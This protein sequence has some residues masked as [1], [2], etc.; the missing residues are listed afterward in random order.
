MNSDSILKKLLDNSFEFIFTLY[1]LSGI[2]KSVILSNFGSSSWFDITIFS[3]GI[4]TVFIIGNILTNGISFYFNG[5][6]WRVISLL[7][8]YLIAII[9]ISY[10]PS[11]NYS[12]YKAFLFLTNVLA[13]ISP[14]FHPNF[15]IYRFI[16][17]IGVF[18][19]LIGVYSFIVYGFYFGVSTNVLGL[20]K[21]FYRSFYLDAGYI[22]GLA[23]ILTLKLK[24]SKY[25]LILLNLSA[26]LL[27]SSAARGPIIFTFISFLIYVSGI[28]LDSGIKGFFQRI[29]KRKETIFIILAVNTLI[30]ITIYSTSFGSTVFNRTLYRFSVISPPNIENAILLGQQSAD[31]DDPF[32]FH[33]D[34]DDSNDPSQSNIDRIEHYVYSWNMINKSWKTRFIGYGFGSY[35]LIKDGTDGR[36][37]PHNIFLEIWFET[38]LL[39][40]LPFLYFIIYGMFWTIKNNQQIVGI[41]VLYLLANTFKSYSLIDHRIIMGIM[42]IA[43]FVTAKQPAFKWLTLPNTGEAIQN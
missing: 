16:K 24:S 29:L 13:I 34:F 38:G 6:I 31:S 33:S 27:W 10:S 21:K 42:G 36:L 18:A 1:L 30:I 17:T 14:F 25:K 3:G 41:A 40:L 15:K 39:G 35:G 20:T 5:K 12:I 11:K 37:Y 26:L 19:A 22:L 8:F 2:I 4:L 7:A 9:S 32:S 23:S 43:I 28:S